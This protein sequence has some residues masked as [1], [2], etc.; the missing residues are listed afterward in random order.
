MHM[1]IRYLAYATVLAIASGIAYYRAMPPTASPDQTPPVASP[2]EPAAAPESASE[3]VSLDRLLE[4]RV[5]PTDETALPTII[6]RA[7]DT[8]PEVADT[9]P[10]LPKIRTE[11]EHYEGEH[12]GTTLDSRSVGAGVAVPTG[13]DGGPSVSVEGAIR[14]DVYNEDPDTKKQDESIGVRVDIPWLGDK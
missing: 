7:A 9:K 11:N 3:K 12:P 5:V 14:Q 1:V 2:A 8:R 4:P 10:L 6:P 13:K